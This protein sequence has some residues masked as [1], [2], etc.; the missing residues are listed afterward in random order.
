MNQSYLP[1]SFLRKISLLGL[2]IFAALFTQKSFAQSAPSGGD[3]V[4]TEF[5]TDNDDVEFIT[6]KRLDL[7]NLHITDNGIQSN[8]TLRSGEGTYT[9]PNTSAWANVPAGTFVR[10][11]ESYGIDDLDPSDGIMTVYGNGD[12]AKAPDFNLSPNGDQVIAYMGLASSP[13]FVA[14]I[15]SAGSDWNNGATNTANSKAPGTASDFEAGNRD[16]ARFS[17]TVSAGNAAAIRAACVNS[18]NWTTGNSLLTEFGLKNILFNQANYTGGSINF[19]AINATG[20]TINA[21]SINFSGTTTDTRYIIV[22]R[23]GGA[24]DNP[25]DRYTCYSGISTVYTAGTSV[26][27]AVGS[28]PCGNATN[29]N[30]KV[31]YFGYGLPSSLVVSGLAT[32]INYQVKVIAVNGNGYTANMS[33]TGASGNQSTTVTCPSAAIAGSNSPVCAGTTLS[34]TSAATG[35]ALS[36]AWT[37]PNGFTSS[38]QNPSISN[39]SASATGTYTVTIS[40]GCG[41]VQASKAVIVNASPTPTFTTSPDGT[42]CINGEETYT[43]QAGKTNYTWTISGVQNSSYQITGGST[44]SNS[45]KIKWLTTGSKTVTVNYSFNGCTG[46]SPATS[47]TTVSPGATAPTIISLGLS[48]F[49]QGGFAIL[50]SNSWTNNLWSNGSTNPFIIVTQSGSYTVTNTSGCSPATSNP[51][52]I[53]VYEHPT[54]TFI[55]AP[56]ATTCA[57][58]NTVYTTQ[59]GQSSYSWNIPG[60]LNTNYNIVAGS[61]ST[62]TVTIKWLTTGSKTVTVN[63]NG[64]GGCSGQTAASS[65]TTVTA[66]PPAATITASGAT[67]FCSGGSVT[68]TSNTATGNVWSTGATTQS[69]TVTQGGS[70]TV[71][72]TNSCSSSTSAPITVTVKARPIPTFTA[73]AGASVCANVNVTYTTQAGQTSYVWS[74]PGVIN[75]NYSIVAGS[76]SSNSITLKWLTTGSKTVT[77]NYS[78]GGCAGASAASTTTN[79]NAGT[80]APVITPSGAITFCQGGSVTLTSNFATGN[81]WSNGATTQSITVTTSG[82]YAVTN[83]NG[84]TTVTSNAVV[85]TVNP[86]PVLTTT[87]LISACGAANVNL[88]AGISSN[89]AGL[90]V[91]FYS[92]AALTNVISNLVTASGTYYVKVTNAAGCSVSGSIAVTL[93][94]NPVLTTAPVSISCGATSVNL[95]SGISSSTA[96]LTVVFYSNAALTNVIGST[97]T[98]AGT[99]YVKVTNASGCT[100]TGS[101]AVTASATPVLTTSAIT[102]TCGAANVNL[103]S[104]IT[105]STAGLTVTF[106]SN[107]AL[108]NV[109][110]NT[111]TTGGTYYVKVTGS[112]GCSSSASI[113]VTM[114]SNPVLTTTSING[115]CGA[116]I[117][118]NSGITSSTTALTVTFYS[119]AALT[120]AISNTVTV[121]GTYYVKVTNAAGCS[122]SASIVVTVGTAPVLTTTAISAA[123]G[124]S[125][126]NLNSGISSSTAGLTVVFYSNA[127]LTNVIAATVTAG[128]TY[129]VKVT[130]ANGCSSS[131]SITVTLQAGPAL[132]TIPITSCATPVVPSEKI[133]IDIKQFGVGSAGAVWNNI[134][135]VSTQNLYNDNSQQTAVGLEFQTEAWNTYDQGAVTGNNSGVYP[136]NAIQDYYYF[137]IFG[138]PDTISFKLT[139]LDPS[140]KYN[141]NLFGSSA[142]TGAGDNGSTVYTINGVSK[143]LNVQLNQQNVAAFAN[144]SPD[145]DSSITV[146]MTKFDGSPAGYLNALVLEKLPPA[147]A[148]VDLNSGIS[149]NTAGLTKTFYSDAALTNV[150][151]N[152]VTVGGTYYVKVTNAGGCSSSA[153][154]PVT[155]AAA[156]S[157]TTTGFTSVCGATSVNLNSGIVSSTAGL[158]VAF[159]SDAALTNPISAT[160]T[161]SGTYYVKFT[162][163]GGCS[164][165]SSIAVVLASA[166]VLTIANIAGTCSATPGEKIF[167]DIKQY[168]EESA[169]APWNY[170]YTTVTNNLVNDNNQVTNTGLE[171]LTDTWTSYNQGAVTGNNSG[172]Y[173]DAVIKDYFYFGIFGA[174]ETVDFKLTN[175]NPALKYNLTL[176]GSS[177]FDGVPDNGTTV[178]TINGV[179]KS[180][181]VQMNQHDTVVFQNLTPDNAGNIIVTMSKAAGSSAGYL[182]ALILEKLAG[183]SSTTDLNTGIT[184]S[185]AG[186]TKVFYSDAALTNVIS[187]LVNSSGTYYVKVTNASGCSSSAAISV[188]IFCPGGGHISSRSAGNESGTDMTGNT[189]RAELKV[190]AAV[191]VPPVALKSLSVYPNPAYAASYVTVAAKQGLFNGKYRITLANYSGKVFSVK[192]MTFSNSSSFRYDFGQLLGPG[193]YMLIIKNTDG[194]QSTVVDFQNL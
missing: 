186:L 169:G 183:T 67:T 194:S 108:T 97:V 34:L 50:V 104:G 68:L 100:A 66:A 127:A 167:V 65:T 129:Y 146:T 164:S 161:A 141:L 43:T 99:Y 105:S 109:I 136:D 55:T 98:A 11:T 180:L 61:T 102:S 107:A 128:G 111:V 16:N 192:E 72:N 176:F 30:G 179:S 187:N 124:V 130:N 10:L 189:E 148:G 175:L 168:G 144:L 23:A 94:A 103:N 82:S 115:A 158:T 156:P 35:S 18:E 77:V 117:N 132:T 150:I 178:Y 139:N 184:S 87:S 93:L 59:A 177:A 37:G 5:Q 174:P 45:I 153:S 88:N 80:G 126:V 57:G 17:E 42:T 147:S 69:I 113:S 44:S 75:T 79:V 47:V 170:A 151:S 140:V 8:G 173:P 22:I 120:T 53:T 91:V 138:A 14:G 162:N 41:S 51:V 74:I 160:V 33:S 92:N 6:L 84:C 110:S 63:Y 145:S 163:A 86:L 58:S 134:Y 54:P 190:T 52:V 62:N 13:A 21:A 106:Y 90:T 118:L 9:F 181:N 172:V 149:S 157:V 133:Y 171:F 96:G 64:P 112:G 135:G 70:Y 152:M 116:T 142:F 123:C 89:T 76:T 154:I 114:L 81:A 40:N 12:V 182:N 155:F 159:Y 122:S 191:N 137:G 27:T 46:T 4:F 121:S 56:G 131:A 193:K 166:P 3:I 101:I 29:G 24:P 143:V 60:T 95:N 73:T 185:T 15:T 26:V 32:G 85:V 7:R 1:I 83:N 188:N 125:S 28:A 119:N 71:S 36:Y 25:V 38:L 39:A 78:N 2:L 165:S 19:S 48:V 31:I 20:F 49:C